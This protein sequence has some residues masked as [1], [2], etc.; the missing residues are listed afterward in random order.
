MTRRW[1][2][3]I[4]GSILS[5][6]VVLGAAWLSARP[7]WQSLGAGDAL[8]RLSFTQSGVRDCRARTP[9]EL[10][11]LPRNMRRDE[12]CERRRAPVYVEMDIDGETVFA[13]NLEPTGLSGTGPSRIYHRFE[14]PAGT[15]KLA[16]RLRTDPA[17]QGYT[18]ELE[19]TVT[20][21][22]GQSLA[23]DYQSEQGGFVL[24]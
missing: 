24:E 16:L 11:A 10:A 17:L 7:S 12:I 14:V 18:N 5:L 15:Y 20:L 4:M 13:R 6:V 21:V 8:I 22:P 2:H 23:V 9:E 1:H 19:Q 3:L